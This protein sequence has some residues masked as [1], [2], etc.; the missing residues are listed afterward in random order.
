[1]VVLDEEQDVDPVILNRESSLD[2]V[3]VVIFGVC[4][5]L[6]VFYLAVAY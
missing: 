1:M 2:R 6:F 3:S 4:L 5:L